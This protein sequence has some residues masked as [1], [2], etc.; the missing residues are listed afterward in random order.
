MSLLT[1]PQANHF[2]TNLGL[3]LESQFNFYNYGLIL[4]TGFLVVIIF[5]IPTV[6]SIE[7]IKATSLFRN[8][9]QLTRFQLGT[10]NILLIL[11][12]LIIL[13][14]IFLLRS[15]KL[16]YTATYFVFFFVFC[17]IFYLLSKTIIY[18]LKRF[19]KFHFLPLRFAVRNII[20]DRSVFPI[21]VLSL[22]IGATLL[23]TLTLV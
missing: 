14:S 6:S 13:L 12:S 18:V 9:F 5:C 3:S 1:I 4:M 17:G 2:I 11:M 22:G 8:I 16:Y 10:K 19:K 20:Q 21:T 15:D 23:L 7:Q